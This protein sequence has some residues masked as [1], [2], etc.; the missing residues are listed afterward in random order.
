MTEVTREPR[1]PL[2]PVQER[3]R[4]SR[5]QLRVKSKSLAA[6]SKIIR[7]AEAKTW[8]SFKVSLA[9]HRRWDVR[10]ESRAT[11]LAIRFMEHKSYEG[12]EQNVKEGYKFE[13]YIVPRVI[14]IVTKYGDV[15]KSEV[16]TKVLAWINSESNV[17]PT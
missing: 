2:T 16:P 7:Q 17:W 5:I 8:G 12:I 11:H 15:P 1:T 13:Q 10:N 3:A 9:E 4:L 6:E 14:A